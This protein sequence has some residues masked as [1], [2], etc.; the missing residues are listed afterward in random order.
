MF[1]A[2]EPVEGWRSFPFGE[3]L[4]KMHVDLVGKS[5]REYA[6]LCIIPNRKLFREHNCRK[7]A[8]IRAEEKRVGRKGRVLE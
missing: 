6:K 7:Y 5:E 1:L 2:R 4:G 3:T 8:G